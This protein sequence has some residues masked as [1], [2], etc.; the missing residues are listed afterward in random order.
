MALKSRLLE[1]RYATHTQP[2]SELNITP[3]I[4]VLLVLLVMIIMSIPIATHSIEVDLPVGTTEVTPNSEHIALVVTENGSVLWNGEPVDRPTLQNRL[5]LA[6]SAP[7]APVIRF[8]PEAN[9]S[10]DAS[11]QVINLVDDA[12]ISKF[13]FAGA[14]QYRTFDAE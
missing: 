1:R 3:L 8:E 13:A 5:A 14:H 6:A 2:M 10:Y 12:N 9:A 4:D 11:V 7:D